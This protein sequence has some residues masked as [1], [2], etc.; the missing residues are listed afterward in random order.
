M[1]FTEWIAK[2]L[3]WAASPLGMFASLWALAVVLRL[4]RWRRLGTALGVFA[5]LLL[6]ALSWP[7][8][9]DLIAGPLETAA[10]DE[11]PDAREGPA[12]A[13]AAGPYDAIVVLGGAVS[14]PV[15]D[16]P[17]R[18]SAQSDR[19]FRAAELYRQGLAPTIL[20]S[21]GD[22]G[23]KPARGMV[24]ADAIAQLLSGP[25]GI[26]RNAL[27]LERNSTTTRENMR[28]SVKLLGDK[29]RIAL[30]TS[31]FHMKR[32]LAEARAA[33]LEPVPFAADF[34]SR[35]G[36]RLPHEQWLPNASALDLSTFAIKEWL[37]LVAMRFR[38]H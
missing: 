28:E 8:V 10:I 1:P 27:V 16:L 15:G 4:A 14:A 38:T 18:L 25:L 32:S 3:T 31:A 5:S 22:F 21:G 29:R 7:P 36:P 37:G 35:V 24:E 2:L 20:I 12:G 13:R 17:A 19:V 30:V 23:D 26:P 34:R 6:L 11:G 9:A 33:G